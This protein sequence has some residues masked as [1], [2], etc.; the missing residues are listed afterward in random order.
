MK[1]RGRPRKVKIEEEEQALELSMEKL[2]LR[3]YTKTPVYIYYPGVDSDVHSYIKNLQQYLD[4]MDLGS[5]V[6]CSGKFVN[7]I[8]IN[9]CYTYD[10][11]PTSW[12]NLNMSNEQVCGIYFKKLPTYPVDFLFENIKRGSYDDMFVLVEEF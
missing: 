4:K 1:K 2:Y 11:E 6:I 8:L 3:G 7:N 5:Q 12:K 9:N 10:E